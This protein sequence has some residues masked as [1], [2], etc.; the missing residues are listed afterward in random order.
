[1]S[2]VVHI[3]PPLIEYAPLMPYAERYRHLEYVPLRV[4]AVL[5]SESLIA[6]DPVRL[7]SLLARAVVNEATQGAGVP[8]EPYRGYIQP[9]PLATLWTSPGGFPLYAAGTFQPVGPA[10]QDSIYLHKR[11]QPGNFTGT[12]TGRWSP[13]PGDGRFRDR[14]IMYPVIVCR[15]W[16]ADAIGN[17]DEIVRLLNRLIGIG[18]RRNVGFGAIKGWRIEPLETFS[19]VQD[20]T[21]IRPLPEDALHLI[22]GCPE[23]VAIKVG[24]TPPYW[25]LALERQGWREGVPVCP[26]P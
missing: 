21:L 14:R 5:R 13:G 8:N 26:A 16:S 17:P 3:E 20:G 25:K 24:W 19:L 18:K 9:A 2:A 7:D 22:D 6:V 4:T 11:Q 12:R 1:M 23:G 15:E 10:L